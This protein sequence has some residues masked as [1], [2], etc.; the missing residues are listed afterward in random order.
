MNANFTAAQAING[1]KSEAYAL[2]AAKAPKYHL[3]SG[4]LF[5]HWSASLLTDNSAHAWSG[6]ADQ[7]RACRR[8]FAAASGCKLSAIV[9]HQITAG[10]EA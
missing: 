3:K 10:E 6:T 4:K 7:A 9:T 2:H 5:L 1:H 8:T